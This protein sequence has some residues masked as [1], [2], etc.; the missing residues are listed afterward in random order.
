[1]FAWS[2]TT[3]AY[4]HGIVFNFEDKWDLDYFLAHSNAKRVTSKWAYDHYHEFPF[5]QVPSSRTLG[6]NKSRK[7]TI[8]AWRQSR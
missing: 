5:I 3:Y 4:W 8:K 2:H 6:A 7:Q 1:M